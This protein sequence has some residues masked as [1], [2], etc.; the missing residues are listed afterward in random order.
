MVSFTTLG[1]MGSPDHTDALIWALTEI[2]PRVVISDEKVE[3]VEVIGRPFR[4]GRSGMLAPEGSGQPIG[5][6][7]FLPG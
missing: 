2:F 4:I 3:P 5:G 7:D 6:R 1:F